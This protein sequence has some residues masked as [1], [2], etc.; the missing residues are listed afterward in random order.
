MAK[1]D[2][3]GRS[4]GEP[5]HVR[6]YHTLMKTDAWREL[7]CV[8]RCAYVELASRY[9]GP[10][11]NNGRIPYSSREMAAALKVSKATA[12][13]AV[14]RL[15][16]VGFVVE[17]KRG[18]FSLKQQHASEWRLTEFGCDVTGAL[19]T[20]DYQSWKKQN[21]VSLMKPGGLSH[22]TAPGP[23]CSNSAHTV[24]S[25]KPHLGPTVSPE[26]H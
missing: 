17:M 19:P 14:Q 25:M 22:E 16:E 4:K 7:D 10:G 6:L 3:R 15:Q 9:G 21:A 2:R 8:A 12:W 11:S 24:S 20:R 26:G 23:Q 5:R 13:R 1:A 18:S